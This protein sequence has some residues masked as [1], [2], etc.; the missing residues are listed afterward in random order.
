MVSK[1]RLYKVNFKKKK[2]VL[3][4]AISFKDAVIKAQKTIGKDKE[5]TNVKKYVTK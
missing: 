5:I 1:Q 2:H 3:V 4:T